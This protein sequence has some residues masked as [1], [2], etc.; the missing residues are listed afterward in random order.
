MMRRINVL[1]AREILRLKN[2]FDF[3]IR[4]IARASSC[5]KSTV[6]DVLERAEKA[7]L[8]WPIELNDKQLMSKLYPPLER[9]GKPPEPDLEYIYKE[10]KK[11][12]VTLGVL[13]EEYKA[14]H[15]DGL[16][17]TQFCERYRNFKKQNN[18]YMHKEH[19]A[20]EEM[21]VDWAGSTLPYFDR[22]SEAHKN[23]HIFVAVLPASS[24]PFAR[25]Y[26][27]ETLPNWIKA[28]TDA[29]KHF[30]GVPAITI[31]DNT[32][33]AVTTP[34]AADPVLN[35]S[36]LEMAR[37][38]GTA[39]MPARPR[40]PKDKAADE[41]MVKI[42]S[43]RILAPLRNM[44]FFSIEEINAA[45]SEQL[46]KLINRPFQK[47]EGNRKSAFEEIDKPALRSLP[48]NKYEY[49]I[50][51][52]SRVQPHYHVEYEGFFYSVPH[53]HINKPCSIRVTTGTVEVFID[54]ERVAAHKKNTSKANR[55]TTLPEHMPL[56]HRVVSGHSNETFIKKAN[57]TGP[58]TAGLVMRILKSA[59]N[60]IE[61]YRICNSILSLAASNKSKTVENASQEAL[62]KEL[63]AF[64]YFKLLLSKHQ[65]SDSV[66]NEER[67]INH[68]N[69][70]GKD[71]F[72]GGVA[73]A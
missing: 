19:K 42:A 9:S 49:A 1:K 63:Y 47:L 68:N 29:F 58:N 50:W 35:R 48:K 11:K 54:G 59:C 46:E 20:G 36:Y 66:E 23:A 32:K 14:E 73:N 7:D 4:D 12:N 37:H 65:K 64:K 61:S 30:G 70:R 25:A 38:Y 44:R 3:S 51:K 53:E 62:E 26:P 17:L 45:I 67:V 39:I 13:W 71:S 15:H 21:E 16:M 18:M 31:P 22:D 33:T 6:S 55:Y 52:E 10:M 69:I 40:K 41:G 8:T 27:D 60:P 57:M 28:H 56:N 43:Q 34:R 5:G 72:T 2:D 24:Y